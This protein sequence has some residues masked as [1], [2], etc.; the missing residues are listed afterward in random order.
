[1]HGPAKPA[2]Q[3]QFRSPG[4]RFQLLSSYNFIVNSVILLEIAEAQGIAVSAKTPITPSTGYS[5]AYRKNRTHGSKSL[6]IR[7]EESVLEPAFSHNDRLLNVD[8]AGCTGSLPPGTGI[9]TSEETRA[10]PKSCLLR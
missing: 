7:R 2:E 1:L 6:A 10:L 8:F 5:F 9:S 3:L 4:R